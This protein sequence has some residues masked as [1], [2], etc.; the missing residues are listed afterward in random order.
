MPALALARKAF[1]GKDLFLLEAEHIR[2]VLLA[3]RV[4][5]SEAHSD[6]RQETGWAL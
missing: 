1:E 2:V 5:A 6:R 4:E 3:I